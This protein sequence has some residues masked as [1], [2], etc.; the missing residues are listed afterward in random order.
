MRFTHPLSASLSA[1]SLLSAVSGAIDTD[2]HAQP[3]PAV[4]DHVLRCNFVLENTEQLELLDLFDIW[5]QSVDL[6]A[7]DN[8]TDPLP[9]FMDIRVMDA[10]QKFILESIIDI[11]SQCEVLIP[12]VQAHIRQANLPLVPLRSSDPMVFFKSY[13]VRN[14]SLVSESN[15]TVEL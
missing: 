10:D 6:K 2:F 1:L 14:E 8:P 4:R 15:P 7:D 13:P 3:F 5:D 9:A 12:D 11:D